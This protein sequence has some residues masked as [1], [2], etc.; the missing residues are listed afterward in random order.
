MSRTKTII[1][2]AL[3]SFGLLAAPLPALADELGSLKDGLQA[4]A[5][6]DWDRLLAD[7]P[8]AGAIGGDILRWQWLRAGEGRLGDYEDFMARRSDWPGLALMK[9]KGEPYKVQLIED[10]PEGET[11]LAKKVAE[12]S[13][14]FSKNRTKS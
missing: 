9:E 11:R 6:Q 2:S 4:A 5:G 10:L 7:V 12:R 3:L 1:R 14:Y 13:F 8:A